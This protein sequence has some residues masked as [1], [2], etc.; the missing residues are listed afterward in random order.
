MSQRS[1]PIVN[2]ER[3]SELQRDIQSEMI[4]R[5]YREISTFQRIQI[6]DQDNK[7]SLWQL[8]VVYSLIKS[9]IRRWRDIFLEIKWR[10]RTEDAFESIAIHSSVQP[11]ED[12][13]DPLYSLDIPNSP[14][15]ISYLDVAVEK[16]GGSNGGLAIIRTINLRSC[17]VPLAAKQTL[18]MKGVKHENLTYFLGSFY[19][20]K[21]WKLSLVYSFMSG[22]SLAE[23]V[24]SF[25]PLAE[26]VIAS[27]AL[28]VCLRTV[29]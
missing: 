26:D 27:V 13:Y 5:E 11:V 1:S 20:R 28:Q 14:P 18:L 17:D 12:L 15:Q 21:E 8:V 24:R 23:V 22:N 7:I 16:H 9:W 25:A 10:R 19:N 2:Q 29:L 4:P 3:V 6:F